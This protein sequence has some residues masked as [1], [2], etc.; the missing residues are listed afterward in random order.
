MTDIFIGVFLGITAFNSGNFNE[1]YKTN[2]SFNMQMYLQI[3]YAPIYIVCIFI[4]LILLAFDL[5]RAFRIIKSSHIAKSFTSKLSQRYF[6]IKGYEYYCFYQHIMKSRSAGDRI[7]FFVY[8]HFSNW[9]R[10]FINSF[11]LL[12]ADGPR[13]ILNFIALWILYQNGTIYQMTINYNIVWSNPQ[14]LAIVSMMLVCLSWTLNMI[15]LL[16]SYLLLIPLFFC[17]IQGSLR[18]YVE[19]KIEKRLT[20]IISEKDLMKHND[21][22]MLQPKYP[23]IEDPYHFQTETDRRLSIPSLN[24]PPQSNSYQGHYQKLPPRIDTN[25]AYLYAAPQQ[26]QYMPISPIQSERPQYYLPSPTSTE[27]FSVISTAPSN[28]MYYEPYPEPPNPNRRQSQQAMQREKRT[29]SAKNSIKRLS[30]N[31]SFEAQ[32]PSPFSHFQ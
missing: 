17:V 13:R 21:S 28:Q 8:A 29:L 2:S 20:N 10:Y 18:K 4:T 22:R 31:S 1:L 7:A 9:K 15:C 11:S 3:L 12:L 25:M 30:D 19:V 23:K 16:I 5:I 6:S 32:N 24:I 27:D 26:P 14:N